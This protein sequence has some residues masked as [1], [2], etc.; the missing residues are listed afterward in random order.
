MTSWT[1]EKKKK[2][3]VPSL[4]TEYMDREQKSERFSGELI[5]ADTIATHGERSKA[6]HLCLQ[7]ESFQGK[8]TPDIHLIFLH[9]PRL[10]T[11]QSY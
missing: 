4:R 8:L 10:I 7:R 5:V 11:Y 2:H 3:T 1:E 6:V 9:N